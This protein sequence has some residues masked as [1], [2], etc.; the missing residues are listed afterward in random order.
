MMIK[1]EQTFSIRISFLV[2]ILSLVYILNTLHFTDGKL[3]SSLFD[4]AMISLKYAQSIA[5][6]NGPYWNM[7][8]KVEGFTNPLWTYILAFIYKISG[9]NIN[10]GP[11]IVQIFC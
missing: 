7:G 11:F 2:F 9:N 8:D 6:G 4:D 1:N 3:Y 5:L 10:L